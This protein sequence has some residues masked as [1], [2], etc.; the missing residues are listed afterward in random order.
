MQ[1]AAAETEHF[2]TDASPSADQERIAPDAREFHDSETAGHT[3]LG[4]L[5]A[6]AAHFGISTSCD[7]LAL[8]YGL[9]E[10]EPVPAQIV[11]IAQKLGLRARAERLNFRA[12]HCPGPGLS[13]HRATRHDNSVVVAGMH[14][15]P[16][17]VRVPCS[18]RLPPRTAFFLLEAE[19]FSGAWTG[20]VRFHPA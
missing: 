19:A 2:E 14:Q 3:A 13:G 20:G 4:C 7:K 1:I 12:P 18:T 11:S 8:E 15:T 17:G 9:S 10:K 5:V 16:D 6:V